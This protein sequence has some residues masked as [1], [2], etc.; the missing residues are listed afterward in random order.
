MKNFLYFDFETQIR[1]KIKKKINWIHN[2]VRTCKTCTVLNITAVAKESRKTTKFHKTSHS[3]RAQVDFKTF[4][5]KMYKK[6]IQQKTSAMFE[7]GKIGTF[8]DKIDNK[9]NQ[10]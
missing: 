7:I 10:E 6:Q 1:K 3:Y 9:K 4:L 2:T 5:P 8:L